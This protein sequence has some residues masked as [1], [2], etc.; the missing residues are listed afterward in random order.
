MANCKLCEKWFLLPLKNGLC[1]D[2][3][4]IVQADIKQRSEII[5]ESHRI[6]ETS[7]NIDSILSR[8]D[9]MIE[10][11]EQLLPYDQ[12]GISTTETPPKTGIKRCREAKIQAIVHYINDQW[13]R[14]RDKSS[15]AKSHSAKTNP[16]NKVLEKITEYQIKL[17]D[18]SELERLEHEI[19]KEQADEVVNFHMESAE[20]AEFKSQNKKALDQYLEALYVMRKDVVPDSEQKQMIEH[21]KTKVREFGGV[22]P[23]DN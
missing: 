22:V 17:D 7:K 9:T 18:I 13:V 23:D 3:T 6:A 15:N 11:F 19:R 20:K 12:R 16:Y 14:A 8:I 5:T 10:N 21:A 4:L 2:C 1:R